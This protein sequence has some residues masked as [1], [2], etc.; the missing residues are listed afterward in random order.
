MRMGADRVAP[1]DPVFFR[2][3]C[4]SGCGDISTEQQASI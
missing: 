3:V 2:L 1:I 4:V